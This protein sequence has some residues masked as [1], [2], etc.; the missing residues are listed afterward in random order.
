MW[1]EIATSGGDVVRA[2]NCR[3]ALL[4]DAGDLNQ[5]NT[6]S[7]VDVERGGKTADQRS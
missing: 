3:P 4:T 6:D 1:I 2:Y 7:D 5:S